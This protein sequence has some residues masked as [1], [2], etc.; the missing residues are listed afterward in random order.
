[1]S[2]KADI[3]AIFTSKINYD[4]LS[5]TY[6]GSDELTQ[7]SFERLFNPTYNNNIVK[8]DQPIKKICCLL[9]SKKLHYKNLPHRF[10]I[11]PKIINAFINTLIDDIDLFPDNDLL[12]SDGFIPTILIYNKDFINRLLQ[13]KGCN[14]FL[15]Y[16]INYPKSFLLDD[17][18]INRSAL[19]HY[20]YDIFCSHNSILRLIKEEFLP[21]FFNEFL[22]Q[23]PHFIMQDVDV[24]LDGL[25]I[26]IDEE[27]I[28]ICLTKCP[29]FHRW[30]LKEYELSEK[31][32]TSEYIISLID[33]GI[34]LKNIY[35]PDELSETP[36]I[37]VIA[38]LKNG[39]N[40]AEVPDDFITPELIK[41]AL[42]NNKFSL[43]YIP[44][45]FEEFI[46]DKN[47]DE[48]FDSI[49]DVKILSKMHDVVRKKSTNFSERNQLII[50]GPYR[51]L[52]KTRS[53]C[54]TISDLFATDRD[55]LLKYGTFRDD[56]GDLLKVEDYIN[57]YEVLSLMDINDYIKYSCLDKSLYM[58]YLSTH[59][60]RAQINKLLL[61]VDKFSIEMMYNLAQIDTNYVIKFPE[62]YWD[63]VLLNKYEQHLIKNT[64]KYMYLLAYIKI[65]LIDPTFINQNIL[66][67]LTTNYEYV[68]L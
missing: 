64:K 19:T 30:L 32:T 38:V 6:F 59:N 39:L 62:K 10:K 34:D 1:M 21:S 3:S 61:F 25:P 41:I 43:L 16:K 15:N 54:K 50:N 35:V 18:D 40:I 60:K 23:H 49:E 36:E 24:L 8:I 22:E 5:P 66:P 26:D 56:I 11:D 46:V 29:S 31:Y 17:I 67:F 7:V 57:D 13:I 63:G 28:E 37:Y 27:Q 58:I 65:R 55:F 51:F 42:S 12:F 68:I 9:K 45:G 53:V 20:C 4:N 47:Y 33:K 52:K 48:L 44:V 2:S 14:I